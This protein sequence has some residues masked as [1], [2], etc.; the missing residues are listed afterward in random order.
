MYI[1]N[2]KKLTNR[3]LALINLFQLAIPYE[4]PVSS[5]NHHQI[6]RKEFFFFLDLKIFK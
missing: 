3:H 2:W 5:G 4:K 6:E 1:Y